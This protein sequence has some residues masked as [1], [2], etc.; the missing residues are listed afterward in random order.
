MVKSKNYNFSK[1]SFL[2]FIGAGINQKFCSLEIF[3]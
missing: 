2:I 3:V 1:K